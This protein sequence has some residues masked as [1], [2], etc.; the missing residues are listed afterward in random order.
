MSS[1]IFKFPT[2][3][4]QNNS[5]R[6]KQTNPYIFKMWMRIQEQIIH[7]PPKSGKA[8]SHVIFLTFL[9]PIRSVHVSFISRLIKIRLVH[10]YQRL[11]GNKNL[12]LSKEK[13]MSFLSKSENLNGKI[14]CNKV[15]VFSSHF[16]VVV[17]LQVPKSDKQTFPFLYKFGLKRTAEKKR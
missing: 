5:K 13:R 11:N 16:S 12:N 6:S 15:D 4:I 10:K 3:K 9:S 2:N 14:T 7:C 1:N 8:N 17:P